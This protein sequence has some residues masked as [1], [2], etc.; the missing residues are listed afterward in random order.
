MKTTYKNIALLLC[1]T[2]LFAACSKD[3]QFTEDLATTNATSS[4][5]PATSANPIFSPLEAASFIDVPYGINENQ[6]YDIYLPTNRSIEKTKVLILIHGG[7][8]MNGDKSTMEHYIPY[9]QKQHPDHAIVNMNY[10]TA[11]YGGAHAFPN[12][13]FDIKEVITSLKYNSFDYNISTEFGLIGGSAGGYLALMYDSVFDAE[14]DVKFVC[15]IVGPTNFDH[16]VYTERP[17]FQLLMQILVDQDVYPNIEE[18]L[19][20]LSPVNQVSEISSPTIMFYNRADSK[21]PLTTAIQ[22]KNNFKELEVPVS[23]TVF[24]GDHGEIQ[25]SERVELEQKLS[26]FI[27]FYLP[28]Q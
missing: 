27:D 21:V 25:D 13:F 10:V 14:D 11:Q 24:R 16:P 6:T 17:D 18:N 26:A 7:S 4:S 22:L 9:L 8:W 2:F 12:Q 5:R 3:E 19:D 23:F 15:S 1:V 28:I 20:V